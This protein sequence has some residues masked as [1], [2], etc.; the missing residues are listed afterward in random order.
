MIKKKDAFASLAPG[1]V[2]VYID[3]GS[4]QNSFYLYVLNDATLES[5][6]DKFSLLLSQMDSPRKALLSYIDLRYT[7]RAFIC[8]KDLACAVE[9]NFGF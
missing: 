8:T 5:R 4:L 7:E 3:R 2:V 6:L 9:W 1:D